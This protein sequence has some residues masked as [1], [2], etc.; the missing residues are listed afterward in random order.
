MTTYRVQEYLHTPDLDVAEGLVVL[1]HI[2]LRRQIGIGICYNVLARSPTEECERSFKRM[3]NV[4][5]RRQMI[6]I[7]F[8]V[9]LTLVQDQGTQELL[10]V[11]FTGSKQIRRDVVST[12]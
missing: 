7:S 9:M 1:I 11:D 5:L 12:N 6:A 3:K 4:V 10:L 8:G 2:P